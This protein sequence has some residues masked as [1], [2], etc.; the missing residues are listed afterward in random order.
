MTASTRLRQMV[1]GSATDVVTC[2]GRGWTNA[3][4]TGRGAS[5]TDAAVMCGGTGTKV[6]TGDGEYF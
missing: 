4:S 2:A 1:I 6:T 5:A 3:T